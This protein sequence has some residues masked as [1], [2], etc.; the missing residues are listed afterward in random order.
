MAE[1]AVRV[2][3]A[4]DWWDDQHPRLQFAPEVHGITKPGFC[5]K[6]K[7]GGYTLVNQF[8]E[9]YAIGIQ[10]ITD[11]DDYCGEFRETAKV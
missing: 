10:V 8:K 3:H 11:A 7:P 6:H 5:R 4:C 1:S 9:S 2:C